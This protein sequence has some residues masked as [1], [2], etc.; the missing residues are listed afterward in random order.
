ME[1]K[2]VANMLTDPETLTRIH[3]SSDDGWLAAPRSQA[4]FA[5]LDQAAVLDAG[6]LDMR[7]AMQV[8]G[9]AFALHAMEKCRQ[10]HKVVLRD[11]DS[12]ECEENGRVNGLFAMVGSPARALGMKW[13]ASFPHNRDRGLPRA[14]ALIILNSPETG[15]PIAV[16]D[17]TLIS[18][19]RTGAVT[20]LGA[21]YLAPKKTRKIGIVGAGVQA[22][23]QVLGL[24]SALDVEEIAVYNRTSMHAED[25]AIECRHRWGAPVHT[26]D[27]VRKAYEDADVVLTVT[28]ALEPLVFCRDIKPGALSIQLSG[29]ECEFDVIRQCQKL[30]TDD[31]D[32]LK[33]RGII[34]PA[35]MYAQQ[36]LRDQ[37]IYA[38][39]GELIVGLK[40]G[41][42]SDSERIHFAHMGMGIADVA[43]AHSVY[44]RALQKNLGIRLQLWDEPLWA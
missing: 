31:W 22:R 11:G 23:T 30:V 26:V 18:A 44:R 40:P 38:N 28:T 3:V 5:F 7:E 37:D 9:E 4:S 43:L 21:R 42:E 15:F 10:P 13:I 24:I 6:V 41:R 17:G 36:L 16:M 29:H 19:V 34:T 35:V 1:T 39:L 8:V 14:S 25:L 20:A 12:V 33:H 32:V 2:A 27:S